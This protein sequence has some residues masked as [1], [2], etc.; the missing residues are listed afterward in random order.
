[1]HAVCPHC[2][3]PIELADAPADEVVCPACGSTFHL[4]PGATT[5]WSPRNGRELGRFE[6][7]DVVGTGAF[8]TVYKA[9]DPGLDRV[10]AIKV[11]RSGNLATGEDLDRF[12]REA[13]SVA[14]LRHPSIVPVYEVGQADQLPYLVSEYV[15][16]MTLS[17]L[18][19]ARRP[20][21]YEAARLM[22]DVA[23]ALQY[24][25]ERGVVHRDIKPSNILLD[26]DGNPHLMDFG[27][28]KRDAGEVTMTAEGQVLGTPAYMS[29]EQ[30]GGEGHRVDGRSDVYSVGVVL[31][32]LLTGEVPFRGNARMLLQQVLH[33]EPRSPRSLNDQIPRDLETVCQRAMTKEPGRGYQTAG[34]LAEDLTRFLKGQPIHARPIGRVERLANWSRR[35]R[36]VAALLAVLALVV[37][38]GIVGL[39]ALWLRAEQHRA[40]AD[41][42]RGDAEEQR[43]AALTAGDREKTQRQLAEERLVQ[44]Q[45][46]NGL[47]FLE[48]GDYFAAL[49]WFVKALQEEKEGPERE[50]IHRMRIAA[51]LRQCPRLAQLWAFD[52]PVTY[53][54]FSPDGRRVV[55]AA[56]G[57][58]WVL[59]VETGRAVARLVQGYILWRASFSPDGRRVFTA[60]NYGRAMVWD[61]AT[62]QPVSLPIDLNGKEGYAAFSA[63]GRRMVTATADAARVWDAESGRPLTPP[64]RHSLKGNSRVVYAAFSPDGRRVATASVAGTARVWDAATGQL[65][66]APLRQLGDVVQLVFSPDGRHLVTSSTDKLAVV[67]DAATG[68]S[69]TALRH[70]GAVRQVAFSADGRN[71]LT[72]SD[73]Q[74]VQVWDART[75]QLLIQ[76]WH[77]KV[78]VTSAAF[79]PDLRKVLTVGEGVRVWHIATG[80]P[81]SPPLGS[82]D[83][84]SHAAFS[85]EGRR[86]VTAGDDGLVRLWDLATDFPASLPPAPPRDPKR[87]LSSSDGRRHLSWLGPEAR[88]FDVATG[89]P[90]G[91]SLKHN[92]G[93]LDAT[94]SPD[95]RCV[96]TASADYTARVWDTETGRPL[97]SPLKHPGPVQHAT[98]SPDCRCVVTADLYWT[99]RVWDAA[100]G[101]P[102]SPPLFRRFLNPPRAGETPQASFSPDGHHILTP[103]EGQSERAWDLHPDDRPLDDLRQ[104]T[105]LLWGNQLDATGGV[106]PLDAGAVKDAWQRLRSKYPRDFSVSPEQVRAWN[107]YNGEAVGEGEKP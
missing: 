68:Q 84:V 103:G 24:A 64:L 90:L 53:A 58:A 43:N 62:S 17:D 97:T 14:Q 65:A 77:Q 93:V 76:P 91:Y 59:D 54:E 3:S 55:T 47:P 106:T 52:A 95:G 10:V 41:R 89:Q 35:H 28:A 75:G 20:S 5:A 48:E 38:G 33:D 29:P 32:Q 15:Q 92:R 57:V 16:G 85:P 104:L 40:A 99:A 69:I 42:A 31:Y 37:S 9:R 80:Q 88:V 44:M 60:N 2:Q 66:I 46:G 98:F 1:M 74:G 50:E 51:L 87:L 13:R 26:E 7:L 94:F 70:T 96:V 30:A 11:P 102:V 101:Q 6:L 79:S 4:E 22:G 45:V 21:P 63:D 25:H 83:R 67:W 71:V 78:V 73:G 72:A 23:E 81:L 49:P 27:L 100:S 36:A 82:T 56:G 34:A 61:V 107:R 86:V 8:G 105:G 39:T 19:T 12:L 18:L